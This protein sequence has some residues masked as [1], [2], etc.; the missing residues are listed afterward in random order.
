M[1]TQPAPRRRTIHPL[2]PGVSSRI[3]AGEVVERPASVVKELIENAL[4]AGA[5]RVALEIRDGGLSL[6]R[7]ADDGCGMPGEEIPLAVRNHTTSKIESFEDLD[8][9]G[10]LG[11]R[12][13]ALASIAAVSELEITSSTGDG[14]GFRLLL[15][16]REE[17]SRG[18]AGRPRGTSVSVRRLFFNTPARKKFMRSA[19][20]E[21]RQIGQVFTAMALAHP[22]IGFVL[23]EEG[24]ELYNLPPEQSLEDRVLAML[25]SGVAS[26]LVPFR[27]GTG[28]TT[29]HGLTSLP[30]FTRGN[31]VLQYLFVNRRFVRDKILSHAVSQ[32]YTSVLPPGRHPAL[33]LF[34]EI[35]PASVD[36]N[37]HPTKLEVRF[38]NEREM[39]GLV[40]DSL[41]RSLSLGD[42][43]LERVRSAHD[44]F[45]H[46]HGESAPFPPP[47]APGERRFPSGQ[48]G[49]AGDGTLLAREEQTGYRGPG[50]GREEPASGEDASGAP[51]PRLPIGSEAAGATGIEAV[52][53]AGEEREAPLFWQ[54]HNTYIFVQIKGG[55]ALVDQHAAHER[56]LLD[57]ARRHLHGSRPTVQRLLFPI[58]LELSVPEYE[59]FLASRDY[60]QS[61]G[62]L[63]EPFGGRSI[64]VQGIPS[65]LRNWA[66]GELLRTILHDLVEGTYPGRETLEQLL[67]SYA[68]RS[69][70]KAGD[71]LTPR[72]MQALMDQL[73]ATEL[74]FSCPHGRPAIVRLDL[75]DLERIFHRK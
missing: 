36:V 33:V 47:A 11:F 67:H 41:R 71:P 50:A 68:C 2:E 53:P 31:R 27:G 8:R 46:R 73:F 75:R 42:D 49:R 72:E 74:P 69:A 6:I 40:K 64:L 1:S 12:G 24:R 26:R 34:C 62:F 14:E 21:K 18:P 15:E 39:H 58:P 17:K 7:V 66:E 16:G 44:A 70:I 22:A 9:L 52:G 60:L 28:G 37:V 43:P 54:L 35:P 30:D 13:E 25:G 51:P 20:A 19:A 48:T 56:V 32:A 4:D 23:T 5:L 61:L 10:T 57:Q 3:A 55:V 45:F 63:V 29:V 59:A 38:R 65:R